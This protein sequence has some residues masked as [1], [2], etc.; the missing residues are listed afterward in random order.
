MMPS[1]ALRLRPVLWFSGLLLLILFVEYLV[2]QR[3]DFSTHPA[4]PAAV[5]FDL[6]VGLPLLF[7]FLVVRRYQ[8]PLTSVVGA[9]VGAVALGYSL[10]PVGQQQYLGWASRSL[11]LLEAAAAVLAVI[12]LRRLLRAYA[13]AAQRSAD[14]VENLHAAFAAVFRRPLA[15][16]VSEL[17]MFRYALL[18]WW[19][20]REVRPGQLAFSSY[21]DSG[22]LALI[23]AFAS[24]SV[25]ETAA[26]HLLVSRWNA[27]AALV[28]LVLDL[29][30]LVFLLAHLRA[31]VLR[32]LTLHHGRL[33]VRV[34]FVWRLE[35]AAGA[36]VQLEELR[37]TPEPDKKCLN[38]ARPLLTPPNVRLTF[39]EPVTVTGL[40]GIRRTVPQV[41]LYVDERAAFLQRLHAMRS[42][43]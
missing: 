30:T 27:T 13:A 22:F 35:V 12:N 42:A 37:D 8:L 11:V 29:Y 19:A 21:C 43:K 24:L 36:I 5:T 10:I 3:P 1:F 25:I 16:L 39:A 4:L 34:G 6:V 32:P 28:L 17:I 23:I 7:Y 15:P 20:R 9:F 38:L 2:V 40:Y 41:A 14:F 31:V 26:V 33:T 18:G